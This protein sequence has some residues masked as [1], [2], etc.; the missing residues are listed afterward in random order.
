MI[1]K[2]T[3]LIS[4]DAFSG[5]S[6]LTSI[7]IPNSVTNI[8]TNAFSECDALIFWGNDPQITEI[9]DLAFSGYKGPC[10]IVPY[11]VMNIRDNAFKNCANLTS[12]TIPGSVTCIEAR[13]FSGCKKVSLRYE[14]T[15]AQWNCVKEGY[16]LD[17]CTMDWL[18]R[19]RDGIESIY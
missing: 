12:V 13:A 1:N 16:H 4:S 11:G 8:G 19:C 18:V 2:E 15:V 10:I 3:K 9:G 6:D 5:C 7:T 14:G 17:L